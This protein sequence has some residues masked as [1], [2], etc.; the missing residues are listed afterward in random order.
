[1]RVPQNHYGR[2]VFAFI[3]RDKKLKIQLMSRPGLLNERIYNIKNKK[4]I[5]NYLIVSLILIVQHTY[6]LRTLVVYKNRI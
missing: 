6:Q 2:S 4:Y 1:M 5:D 3:T